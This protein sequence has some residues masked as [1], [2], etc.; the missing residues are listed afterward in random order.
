MVQGTNY[1]KMVQ[2]ACKLGKGLQ[3]VVQ[4][5]LQRNA[6]FAHPEAI[7]LSMLADSDGVI[8]AQAVDTIL[9]ICMKTNTA[10]QSSTDTLPPDDRGVDEIDDDNE[11]SDDEE[12][13]FT[14]EP[15][16]ANAISSST[17]RKYRLPK[18]NFMAE[19]YVDLIDWEQSFL[20]EPP[21]T[22]EKNRCRNF[23]FQGFI[24][25]GTQISL[26]HTGC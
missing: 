18:I 11:L 25:S 15:S 12:A 2:T 6:Y 20:T 19:S 23:C 3:K 22:L 14:L 8:R 4:K 24:I 17:I 1:F 13:A 26:S 5:T 9:T 7:L 21:L 16:E 10:S